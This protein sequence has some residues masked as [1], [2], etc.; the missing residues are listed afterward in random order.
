MENQKTSAKQIMINYGLLLAFVGIVI[1]LANFSFGN[2][3]KPHWSIQ[4]VSTIAIVVFVVLG[5]KKLKESNGGF[6]KLG[7]ALKIGIGIT[8]IA[9]II[10]AI[11]F[12]LF[13]NFIEPD[14]VKNI[15]EV[16]RQ[17]M[18][19]KMPDVSD[20]ILTKQAEMTQKYF[21][22]FT[23]GGIIFFNLFL[24]FVISLISGLIMKKTD[25]EITSI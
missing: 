4:V 8:F 7:E 2:I 23:F 13:A 21:Y 11:Y 20:E 9:A 24:G 19:D 5:I 10:S 18:L 12:Y 6:L 1:S 15:I 14:F 3:Y 22:I 17:N 16:N 25:E